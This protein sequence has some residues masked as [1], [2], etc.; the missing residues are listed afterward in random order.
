[1]LLLLLIPLLAIIYFMSVRK[2]A[3]R[4]RKFGDVQLLKTLMPDYSA[5][6]NRLK[7]LLLVS[8]FALLVMALARPQFGTKITNDTR[9]GIEMV[10]A[11][12][13]SN[14]MMAE[15]IVPSRL[16]KSK[17][18]VETIVDKFHNDK[19]GI[20]VFAGDAFV[21][22]PIT[23]DYV[24]AKMFMNNITPSLISTQ[25]TDVARAIEVARH[26]FTKDENV[27]RAILVITDG[28]DHEGGALEAAKAAKKDGINIFVV[29]VGSAKGAVIPDGAGNYITDN[30]GQVVTSCL[31]EDMCKDIARAGGGMYI[32]LDN[33]NSAGNRLDSE[34][35][36]LQKGEISSTVYSE[37]DEQFQAFILLA[38]LLLAIEI[39]V[40]ETK[41]RFFENMRIFNRKDNKLKM[42]FVL[43]MCSVSLGGMAQQDRAY[44]RKGNALYRS[45]NFEKAEV[46]YRKAIARNPNN[47]Q[48]VYNLGCAMMMQQKDS[49]AISM[50]QKSGQIESN[51]IR[52]S[53][54][55]H[56]IGVLCQKYRMYGEAV[57]AYK[58]ALRNNPSDDE[59][60]YNLV[61][62]KR[63]QKESPKKNQQ[64]RQNDDK[65][66]NNGKEKQ[67]NSNK[68]DKNN[69]QQ[70]NNISKEN[71]E[72]LLNA[73]MQ[74][75]KATQQRMK[76]AMRQ[77]RSRRL[78][79]NW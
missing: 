4:L 25:G 40:F 64:P 74:N 63:L 28:E 17:L 23:S 21:Q 19:I 30:T 78:Q 3:R 71:A 7:A 65:N 5:F 70:E 66:K 33:T 77:P 37:Y 54:S 31:N 8:S 73:A 15:D 34:L 79:K 39:C 14:S 47:A 67:D 76:K 11:M 12:D 38:L 75:E 26:S 56:N 52:K 53:K 50:F 35:G 18:L 45:Q 36:R 2:R 6:R 43:L 20:V 60:R 42:V 51:K 55:Y 46:E 41:G 49:A 58:E 1:M 32:N 61:L 10:I 68:Q 59:T 24:S 69:K 9:R 62:C 16:D 57:E 72:Q 27:G 48:A 44:V 29:G 22:L 13:I